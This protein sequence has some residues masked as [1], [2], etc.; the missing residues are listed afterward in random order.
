MQDFLVDRLPCSGIVGSQIVKQ[1]CQPRP[2]ARRD[3]SRKDAI[4]LVSR[5]IALYLT[6]WALPELTNL[7]VRVLSFVHSVTAERMAPNTQ[8]LRQY[9]LMELAFLLT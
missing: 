3:V 2:D 7:P 9:Y 4:S 1:A 5:A 8:Y 6:F